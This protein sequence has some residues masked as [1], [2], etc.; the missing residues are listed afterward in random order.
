MNKSEA[1]FSKFFSLAYKYIFVT[2][3]FSLFVL[4]FNNAASQDVSFAPPVE[5]AVGFKPWQITKGDFNLD[6]NLDLGVVNESSG[7]FS[8]LLG[9]GGG[10][11]T[12]LPPASTGGVGP[13]GIATGDFNSDGKP[14][15]AIV[16]RDNDSIAVFLGSGTGFFVASGFFSTGGDVP[17]QVTTG[18]FNADG[19]LDLAVTNILTNNISIFLGTG[20]GSFGSPST[21]PVG[22]LPISIVA[23]DFNND[24]KLDLAVTNTANINTISVLLGLGTGTF[25]TPMSFPLLG[26]TP[27]PVLV[28]RPVSIA[29]GD[30]N[31]NGNLDLAAANSLG[32][33]VAV[34]LGTGTGSFGPATHFS[35]GS[36]PLGVVAED[37]NRDGIL[38]LAVTNFEGNNMSVLLGTGTG[39]FGIAANFPTGNNN[40]R[41][42]GITSGDFNG[43]GNSDLAV[44]NFNLNSTGI[45]TVAILLNNTVLSVDIDIKPG[46]FPNSINLGSGGTVPVAIFSTPA[47]DATT[48]DPVTVTLASAPVKLKG[49]GSPMASFQDIN[50]DGLLDLVVHVDTTALQLNL[51][52]T[53]AVLEGQTVN[54]IHIRGTDYV[55]I[56]P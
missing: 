5:Y 36:Q 15:L 12:G 19:N 13:T 37:L 30:L 52:D 44:T 49:K 48:V 33:T 29:T 40:D 55:R 21:L 3:V 14:D 28:I 6:G 38:D 16:N 8:I 18:D 17:E 22:T 54:G 4:H 45:G 34:L 23:G 11:F 26:G 25:E 39:S 46:S 47:F 42:K 10:S 9:T 27:N 7:S 20:T 56:V 41:T 24:G 32:D 50:Q 53:Q 31:R 51:A 2:L 43:D 35:V 1:N